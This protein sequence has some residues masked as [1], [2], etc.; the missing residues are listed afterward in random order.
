MRFV[1]PVR[2]IVVNLKGDQ[3]KNFLS[4]YIQPDTKSVELKKYVLNAENM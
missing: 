1:V 2:E 4:K 3:T